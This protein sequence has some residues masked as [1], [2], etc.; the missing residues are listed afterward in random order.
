MRVNAL[1]KE[2]TLTEAEYNT[3]IHQKRDLMAKA[4]KWIAEN[5]DVMIYPRNAVI[6]NFKKAMSK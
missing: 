5:I 2:I 3:L 1:T 4:E 6:E